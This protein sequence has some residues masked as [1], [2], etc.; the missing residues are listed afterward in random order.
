MKQEVLQTDKEYF[1]HVFV[2]SEECKEAKVPKYF[3]KIV[4]VILV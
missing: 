3:I 2:M 4:L 1:V